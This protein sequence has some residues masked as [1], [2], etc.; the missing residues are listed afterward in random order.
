MED[1][2]P[3]WLLKRHAHLYGTGPIARRW[4]AL[5]DPE[6]VHHGTWDGLAIQLRSVCVDCNNGWMSELETDT[7][8]VLG[9]MLSGLAV[10][11][12]RSEQ[13][14]LAFWAVKTA[15]VL[16]EA[17]RSLGLPIPRE[18]IAALY[19]ERDSRPRVPPDQ[20][21]VWLARQRGPSVG[22]AYIVG[23]STSPTGRFT[24]RDPAEEHR[25]WVGLRVGTVAFHILGHTM[26]PTNVQQ[27][28][29]PNALMQLWPPAGLV[30]PWPPHVGFDDA[31]FD[32]LARTTLPQADVRRGG[33]WVPGR[34][35]HR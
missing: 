27:A 23:Y 34:A 29:N 26:A 20:T 15:A 33:I 9:Q 19:R 2:I 18:H 8:P 12:Y 21:I 17:N 7:L 16:Q 22:L 14:I 24:P 13:R 1:A 32:T 5:D 3:R 28:A 35:L 31:G 10:Q 6:L 30:F 25:Y 4:G 11:L